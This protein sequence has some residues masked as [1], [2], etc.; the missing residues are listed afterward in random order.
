[1]KQ[2]VGRLI[3]SETDCGGLLICD[4]RLTQK[5]YAKKILAALPP[6]AQAD[7]YDAFLQALQALTRFSTTDLGRP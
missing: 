6:M 4:V 1:L 2:G 7:S 5:S 3:R